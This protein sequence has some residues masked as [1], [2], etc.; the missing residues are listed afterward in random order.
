MSFF[1]TNGILS[2][3]INEKGAE[4]TSLCRCK[5]GLEYIWQGDPNIW[6]AHSPLLFPIIGKQKDDYYT[7]NNKRYNMPMHGF[8]RDQVFELKEQNTESVTLYI[9]DSENTRNYYP[10]KFCLYSTFSLHEST[11]IITRCVKNLSESPMPF[12]L[13]EHTGYRVPLFPEEHYEEYSLIFQTLETAERWP[14][15][16]RLIVAP[17]PYLINQDSLQL[18]PDLFNQGALILKSLK[19]KEVTIR[20]QKYGNILTVSFNDYPYIAFW[21]FPNTNFICIEPWHGIPSGKDDDH[22]IFKKDCIAVLEQGQSMEFTTHIT[23]C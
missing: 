20:S 13:G 12:S 10:Y 17:E 22:D 21:A 23:V 7:L 6:P 18:T 4:L 8:A 19:S 5:D 14:I 16:E 11:L 2:A 15:E 3:K 9:Q 1:I